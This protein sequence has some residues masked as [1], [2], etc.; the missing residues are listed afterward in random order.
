MKKIGV[1]IVLLLL[2]LSFTS[3][4]LAADNETNSTTN[5]TSSETKTSTTSTTTSTTSQ[6]DEE[7]GV[8]KAYTCLEEKVDGQC[9][10]LSI[11]EISLTILATPKDDVFDE[12]LLALQEKQSSNG[13][14]GDASCN[15]LDTAMAIIA[16]DHSGEDS[17]DAEKWLLTQNQTPTDLIWYLQQDSNEA[18]E[19]KISYNA[20]DYSINFGENKKIDSDAGSCLDRAQSNFWLKVNPDCYETEFAVSCNKQFI[21]NLIYRNKNSPTIYV[22]EG[23]ESA[24]AFGNINLNINSQCFPGSGTAGCS[25]EATAWATLAL[26]KTGYDIDSFIPYIIAMSDSNERYLPNAFVHMATGYDDYANS[27]INQQKLGNYW[28]ADSS[29][30]NRYYDTALA[31]VAL[32]GS[33]SEQATLAKDWLLF[34]QQTEGCWNNNIRDTAIVLWALTGRG[35]RGGSGGGGVTYCSEANFFCIPNSECPSNQQLDNYFCAGLSTTCCENENLQSCSE[36]GGQVCD[37]D[38]ICQ[39]N[40]RKSTDSNEC[41]LG[42]CEE[43]VQLSECEQTGFICRSSCAD[44]QEE[45]SFECGSSS[46]CCKTKTSSGSLWWL[47]II[48]LLILI[49]LV[50]LAIIYRE[51]VKL[52]YFK[53]KSKFKKDKGKNGPSNGPQGPRPG[54]PPR[55]GFPPFRR[56]MPPRGPP[57]P[58]MPSR[59]NRNNKLD[60]TFKKL[61]D[62]S[63]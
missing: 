1:F 8:D 40:S 13:C 33:T 34:S 23:T 54:M 28:E 15:V 18:T 38:L 59:F 57:R 49:A 61:Q 3:L 5:T 43:A 2:V 42:T 47:W 9:S 60:N 29:A 51:K 46:V 52:Y 58:G 32:R 14:F 11:Q 63:K 4:T 24:E 25:Y 26:L 37:S 41:C 21:A 62:M 22:L 35:G 45:V 19:C 48:L 12:C 36:Y 50:V 27:L 44:G 17:E 30:Y 31:L 16:L 53:V 39:G 10:D 55:P 56:P 6:Q 20:N 7:E